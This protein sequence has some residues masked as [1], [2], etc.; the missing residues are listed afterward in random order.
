MPD[1][2]RMIRMETKRKEAGKPASLRLVL[3]NNAG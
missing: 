2:K 1:S 3:R